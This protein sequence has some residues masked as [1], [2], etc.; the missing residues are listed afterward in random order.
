VQHNFIQGRRTANV[1]AACLYVVCRRA[2]SNCSIL[3]IDFADALRTNMVGN[4]V[5]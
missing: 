2:K 5:G 4:M 1:V 3:L